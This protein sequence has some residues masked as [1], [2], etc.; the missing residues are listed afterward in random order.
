[1]PSFTPKP[2]LPPTDTDE[3]VEGFLEAGTIWLWMNIVL[4]IVGL[5]AAVVTFLIVLTRLGR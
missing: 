3:N 5:V 1:L 4:G 2:T